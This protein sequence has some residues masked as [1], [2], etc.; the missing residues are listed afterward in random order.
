[1]LSNGSSPVRAP[2]G[3]SYRKEQAPRR[4]VSYRKRPPQAGRVETQR[5]NM[6]YRPITDFWFL[7]RCKY[8]NGIRRYGGYLGGFPERARVLIGAGIDEPVLHV[9]GGMAKHYPYRG[10][11]GAND[12]TLD[13]DPA[14][15]PDM[16]R[17]IRRPLSEDDWAGM[18]ADPPY[19]PADAANY[20]PGE[21]AFPSANLIVQNCIDGLN[22][23]KKVGIIHYVVPACP[24][25]AKFV[26]CVGVV[27]GFNNRIR[28]F[29]VF[30]KITERVFSFEERRQKVFDSLMNGT[31]ECE[32]PAGL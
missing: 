6:N 18:I 32:Q 16:L 20:P 10:G 21:A 22:V 27:C 30:E 13:L 31:K 25:E 19:T 8:K 24:K 26:A 5:L 2:L 28:A 15:E 14:T 7:A 1:M 23:G 29:S 17:D 9:C 3:A 11:F 4:G 12:Q